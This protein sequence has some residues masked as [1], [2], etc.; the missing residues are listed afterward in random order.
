M[1][2][3]GR[4]RTVSSPAL[5]WTI[6]LIKH[7]RLNARSNR[8]HSE[9][10]ILQPGQTVRVD[11]VWGVSENRSGVLGMAEKYSDRDWQIESSNLRGLAVQSCSSN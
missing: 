9:T 6:P 11:I 4:G 3:I 2:F 10:L 1:K 5:R 8:Q 7:C